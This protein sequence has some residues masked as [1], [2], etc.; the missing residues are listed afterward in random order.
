MFQW[1]LS[2]TIQSNFRYMKK[3]FQFVV[4]FRSI[5]ANGL[6]IYAVPDA[7]TLKISRNHNRVLHIYLLVSSSYY[8][9]N[10]KTKDRKMAQ[11][12]RR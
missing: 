11:L 5:S 3:H 12:R 8:Y 7:E 6:G 10:I 4:G 2:M 1:D 9:E